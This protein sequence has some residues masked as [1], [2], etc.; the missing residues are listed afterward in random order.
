M[1]FRDAAELWGKN[2]FDTTTMLEQELGK[3]FCIACISTGGENLV[4]YATIMNE[5]HRALGRGG[6]GAVMG[7]KKLKAVM[8]SR[9][10]GRSRS[11]TRTPSRRRP[12]SPRTSSA[13][14]CSR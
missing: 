6:F 4:R 14:A 9:V 11:S 1:E 5:R 3:G 12:R 2:V 7:S 13:R 10:T 8:G